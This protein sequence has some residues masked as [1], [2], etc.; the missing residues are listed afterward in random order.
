M[1]AQAVLIGETIAGMK[2]AINRR[3]DASDS[4]DSIHQPTNRGNKLMRKA[5]F[6]REGQLD[7]PN[8]PRVYKRVR[9]G[10]GDRPK[11]SLTPAQKIEH[12]G[13]RRT[14]ISRNPRRYDE[15]GDELDDDEVDALADAAAA[16]QNPYADVRLEHILAPL[17]AAA[18]LTTHASLSAPYLSRTL[19]DMA[20]QAAEMVHRERASLWRTKHLLTKF[21]DETWVPCG[22]LET[23]DD[24]ALFGALHV[25]VQISE[26][27]SQAED[28]EA[29]VAVEAAPAVEAGET[30]E[31]MGDE[32]ADGVA[33][34]PAVQVEA[35]TDEAA[36][37]DVAM[38]DAPPDVDVPAVNGEGDP[39]EGTDDAEREETKVVDGMVEDSKPDADGDGTNAEEATTPEAPAE[40]QAVPADATSAKPVAAT[41]PPDA[42]E[43]DKW[44]A[45]PTSAA[46]A[47]AESRVEADV[48]VEAEAEGEGDAE[49]EEE[50]E[51]EAEA[52]EAPAA[53]HRMTTR[54]QAQAATDPT[55]PLSPAAHTTSLPTIHPLFLLPA[56][57]RPDTNFSLPGPEAE[58]TRRLLLSYV[59]K[60]EEV[61]RGAERL[62][63]GLL[64]A[65]RLRRTVALWSRAEAHVGEMSDGEDWVDLEEWGL[66]EGL[67]KGREEDEEEA[68]VAANAGGGRRRRGG[69]RA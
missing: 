49:A 26:V 25:E 33:G 63:S 47:E 39:V 67:K 35:D 22:V 40:E 61:C 54:A 10:V 42:Q 11:S 41:S 50:A 2:K 6:V 8:G 57:T 24:A 59:Q 17:T 45:S 36:E 18:D 23:E 52:G 44:P 30:A 64:R 37:D 29:V 56:H 62:H 60:Q 13:Y 3:E 28:I 14:I 4:D 16:E 27:A 65:D 66:E 38:V 69:G 20:R 58:E 48:E 34:E 53:P 7:L 32:A 1:A 9:A 46:A 19:P 15:D 12:A 31:A 55:P 21:R 51:A 68:A 5:H 43:P